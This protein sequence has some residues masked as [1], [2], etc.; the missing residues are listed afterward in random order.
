MTNGELEIG[1]KYNWQSQ[2]ERLVY[3]GLDW[4]GR[5]H[6]FAKVESPHRVWC[7]VQAADLHM[8]ERTK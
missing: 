2:P 6:Q 1:G 5:W 8:M 3:V 4:T 7:E